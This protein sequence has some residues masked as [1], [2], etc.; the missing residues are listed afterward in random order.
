MVEVYGLLSWFFITCIVLRMKNGKPRRSIAICEGWKA[1]NQN[2]H[3]QY[4][5]DEKLSTKTIICNV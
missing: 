1:V 2:D 3:L 5:K 4:V